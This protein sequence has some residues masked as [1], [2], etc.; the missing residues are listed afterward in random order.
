MCNFFT[1][2]FLWEA[3]IYYILDLV[4]QTP[5][6][7]SL[8]GIDQKS[9]TYL[10]RPLVTEDTHNYHKGGV[11]EEIKSRLKGDYGLR[12]YNEGLRDWALSEMKIIHGYTRY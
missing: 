6:Q 11:F 8:I 2:S 10:Y 1:L 12:H 4:R 3:R 9:I 7:L 5:G